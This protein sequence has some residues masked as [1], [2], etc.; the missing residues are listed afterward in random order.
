M[1]AL[2]QILQEITAFENQLSRRHFI[3][4]ALLIAVVPSI[5]LSTESKQFIDA[6]AATLIPATALQST[7][8][9]VGQNL[10]LLLS[11]GSAD[12]RRK[13]TRFLAWSQRA[14]ILYGGEKVALN[15]RGSRF[16]LVRKMGRTLSS[17]CLVAF[18][19]DERALTLIDNVEALA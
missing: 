19:A 11:S 7:G 8:I 13:V 17:L 5:S 6:V 15:A 16:M 18:W 14:S 4:A 2:E 1:E 9:K 12:H 3:G 10:D